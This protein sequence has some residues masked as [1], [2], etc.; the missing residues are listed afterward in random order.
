MNEPKITVIIP[1]RERC[2]VLGKTLQ[3]VVAQ[4]Y[5]QLEIIVSDNFSADHT[6]DVVEAFD[7]P[8]I[9]YV[10]TG[11]RLSMSHNWEFALSHVADGW[12]TILGDDDG[13][14]PNALAKIARLVRSN[15]TEAIRS[16]VCGYGWPGSDGTSFG[17]LT[18]PLASG[19]EQRK[20][21]E[22]L[23]RVLEGKTPYT[24]LPMLYNG[25]F[26][27]HAVVERIRRMTG[28]I[29]RSSIPDIYGAVAIASVT[30]DYLFCHEPLAINGASRHSTGTAYFSN[31]AKLPSC[32]A[33]LFHSEGIIPIHA[34]MA[35]SDDGRFPKSLQAM[36]FESYLQSAD[37]RPNAP[38]L[39]HA[40]ELRLV[41]ATDFQH[42]PEVQQWGRRFAQRHGLDYEAIE[43]SSTSVK[44]RLRLA[45][46][47]RNVVGELRSF[48][49]DGSCDLPLWDVH[50][51]SIAAASILQFG[52]RYRGWP[53]VLRRVARKLGIRNKQLEVQVR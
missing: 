37:L 52:S 23:G 28:N 31:R 39:P 3:T 29:Y 47:A 22:W 53:R 44:R 5:D 36:V 16:R 48:Q 50:E 41:L 14:L 30:E 12:L 35:A 24:D 33:D 1:T 11:R 32:S 40:T 43:R 27:A 42:N 9:R 49:L 2:D 51:A 13:L 19:F 34:D 18:V 15:A 7:D 8:R 6:R 4:D 17:S 21:A 38:P 45:A 26:V 25:G 20:S 10:N 46:G